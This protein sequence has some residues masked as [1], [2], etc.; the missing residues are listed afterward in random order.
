LSP[1]SKVGVSHLSTPYAFRP[2]PFPSPNQM[3]RPFHIVVFAIDVFGVDDKEVNTLLGLGSVPA[4]VGVVAL[5]N[6]LSPVVPDADVVFFD[7]LAVARLPC[8]VVSVCVGAECVGNIEF[9]VFLNRDEFRHFTFT[10]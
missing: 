2:S 9:N 6:H 7:K 3:H 8:L 5:I 4:L 10:A 1:F